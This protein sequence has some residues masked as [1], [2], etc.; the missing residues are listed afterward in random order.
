MPFNFNEAVPIP[1]NHSIAVIGAVQVAVP[2]NK[3]LDGNGGCPDY[4][5]EKE[6]KNQGC[7]G[8]HWSYENK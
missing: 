5:L 6:N 3:D 4:L 8:S 1:I 2:K 7:P